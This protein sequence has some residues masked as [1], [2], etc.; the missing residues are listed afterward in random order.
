MAENLLTDARLR[1]ASI[2]RDGL[3]LP[4]GGGLRFRLL[5]SGAK[6]AY[7]SFKIKRADGSYAQ[8]QAHLGTIGDAFTDAAGVARKFTLADARVARDAARALVKRGVDPREAS[9]LADL[10]EVEAQRERL[11]ELDNRRTVEGAFKQWLALYVEHHRADGGLF[12]DAL[13]RRH[14]LPVIG[15]LPL[16]SLKL[17]HV[18]D[19]LDA[20]TA[21]GIRRTAN[22][23]LSLLRQ[24]VRWALVKGWIENDPTLLLTRAQAGGKEKSRQR[25]LSMLEIVELRDKLPASALPERMTCAVWLLLATG[26]R[27]GELSAAKVVDFDLDAKTWLI[28][29]NKSDRPHLV[30]L[31]TFA[32]RHVERLIELGESS[33]YLLPGRGGNAIG[34]KAIAKALGDRQRTVPLKGRT[35][36]AATLLLAGGAWTPH[37]L[38]RSMATRMRETLRVSSDVVERALNHAA[39]GIVGTYQVGELLDERKDAFEAWG[40]A[41]DRLLTT[42][43][44]AASSNVVTLQRAAP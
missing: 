42:A 36:R 44:G 5:P 37:D 28:A 29:E 2:K 10:E 6:L 38:R 18:A 7:V 32:L 39:E 41:L 43:A 8:G 11:A 13:F 4:D 20:I 9:R 3:Y 19:L 21:Q 24:F 26:A 22:M 35:K 16:Q 34:D 15:A 27:V 31:S 1:T 33:E 17:A 23:T 40:V 12:V 30:H 14:V 25:A